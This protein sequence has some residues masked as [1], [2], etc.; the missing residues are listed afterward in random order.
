[1]PA[2]AP[3][4]SSMTHSFVPKAR[5]VMREEDRSP[6]VVRR[7]TRKRARLPDRP[8]PPPDPLPR[9]GHEGM[10]NTKA[11]PRPVLRVLPPPH[12]ETRVMSAAIPP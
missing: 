8:C 2:L 5:T 6:R 9:G 3:P 12:G 4:P 10:E 11:G 1:M 7:V